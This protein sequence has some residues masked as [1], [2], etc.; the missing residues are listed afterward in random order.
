MLS[1]LQCWPSLDIT[2]TGF[3]SILFI[4]TSFHIELENRVFH[5]IRP[6]GSSQL[7]PT[8]K[9]M[10]VQFPLKCFYFL[11]AYLPPLFSF[12]QHTLTI[13]LKEVIQ[14]KICNKTVEFC[15]THIYSVHRVKRQG[16][17]FIVQ[18]NWWL[19][20]SSFFDKFR[21]ECV[22]YSLYALRASCN[23]SAFDAEFKLWLLVWCSRKKC[24]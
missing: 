17:N 8:P 12:N 6:F 9:T 1:Y 18:T 19:T 16:W 22:V 15:L 7:A 2:I 10:S 24:N 4:S 5:I 14:F 11:T 20:S 3:I 21:D 23:K 13:C